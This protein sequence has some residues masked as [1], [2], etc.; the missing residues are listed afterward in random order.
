MGDW[1]VIWPAET[2]C[3]YSLELSFRGIG[4][5]VEYCPEKRAVKKR[6]VRPVPLG[7]IETGR[8]SGLQGSVL[9]DRVQS[10]VLPPKRTVK[11]K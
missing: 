4:F 2:C 9:G 1:K 7:P 11:V 6:K 3:N 8:S 10:G 5:Q